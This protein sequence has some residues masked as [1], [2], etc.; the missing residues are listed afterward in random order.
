MSILTVQIKHVFVDGDETMTTVS[1]QRKSRVAV[2][3]SYALTPLTLSMVLRGSFTQTQF[4]DWS[5]KVQ[6]N[7]VALPSLL[8]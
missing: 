6:R 2:N 8:V 3:T 4:A 7:N 5:N 1:L